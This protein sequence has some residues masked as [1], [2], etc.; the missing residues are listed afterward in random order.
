MGRIIQCSTLGKKGHFGNQLFQY[1]FC[2]TYAEETRSV[3]EIPKDWI[4]RL[5]FEEAEKEEKIKKSLIN[6]PEEDLL[7]LGNYGITNIDIVGFFQ[8]PMFYKRI[9]LTKCR[10]WLKVKSKWE[11]KFRKKK[12]YYIALHLRR[13]DFLT[14]HW[15]YP[16]IQE[17]NYLRE[18]Y[19]RGYDPND[20]IWIS[21]AC[22]NLD[23]ECSSLGIPFLP[24]FMELINA[25]V[26]FRG[27][28]TFSFWAGVIGCNK[29][30][31]PSADF[32][33]YGRVG[34]INDVEFKLGLGPFKEGIFKP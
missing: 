8:H 1:I 19:E 18:L 13:G 28:S 3:L 26:L 6:F 32:P 24:D 31:S 7:E 4:G 27:P 2:K 17:G 29:M 21:D 14:Q 9:S 11:I 34:F 25:D 16:V 20:A 30:Y 12:P 23:S 22:P 15:S 10:E 33:N 5:I